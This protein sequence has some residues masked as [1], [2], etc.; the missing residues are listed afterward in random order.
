MKFLEYTKT[1]NK[2]TCK[3][4][5]LAFLS[6]QVIYK[7]SENNFR[8]LS[9][10]IA[11]YYAETSLR[12]S[13]DNERNQNNCALIPKATAKEIDRRCCWVWFGHEGAYIFTSTQS[14]DILYAFR[15]K[16]VQLQTLFPFRVNDIETVL[17]GS[18]IVTITF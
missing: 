2:I 9:I 16:D 1:K 15:M 12:K 6:Q 5:I 11:L 14:N 10:Q 13:K 7:E 3:K 18:E 17:S 8:L 4:V